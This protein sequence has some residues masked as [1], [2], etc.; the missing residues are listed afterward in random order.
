MKLPLRRSFDVLGTGIMVPSNTS[1]D[2]IK[3]SSGSAWC[4]LWV[5]KRKCTI[6]FRRHSCVL[7]QDQWGFSQREIACLLS[8]SEKSVSAYISRGREQLRRLYTHLAA[9]SQET[10]EGETGR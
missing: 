10:K 9:E 4:T 7:L 1:T 2:A 6:S 5:R 8:I 3:H